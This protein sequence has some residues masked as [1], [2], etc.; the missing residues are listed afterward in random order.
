VELAAQEEIAEIT[1]RRAR[2]ELKCVKKHI[3]HRLRQEA[4]GR[5]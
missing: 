1:L 4:W 2:D 3:G 5:E